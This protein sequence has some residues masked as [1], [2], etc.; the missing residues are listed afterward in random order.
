[1]EWLIHLFL[2]CP[3]NKTTWNM[4]R[5]QDKQIAL[6]ISRIRMC[7]DLIKFTNLKYFLWSKKAYQC[8]CKLLR[9]FKKSLIGEK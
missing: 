9:E 2:I 5:M 8:N 6:F 4:C 7:F 1:M 3:D